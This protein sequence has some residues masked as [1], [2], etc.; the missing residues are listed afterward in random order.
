M[1]VPRTARQHAFVQLANDLAGPI[2][3]RAEQ[4]DRASQF[5]YESFREL[6]DAGYL[7]LTIPEAFGGRGADPLEFGL[8]QERIAHACGSTGLASTMH[9][10]LLGRLGETRLWP[11]DVYGR[12]ARDV[13]ANGALINAANSEPDLGSPS[14]GALP[15]TT[16]VRTPTGW[17]INGRK[18][19]ASLAPALSWVYSLV[20]VQEEG[21]PPRRGNMLIPMSASGVSVIETWDNLGMRGTASHDLLF[22]NV[23]VGLDALLPSEGSSAPGDGQAWWSIPGGAVY[24]G[25]GLAARDAAA[26][27][28]RARIPNGMPGPIAELQMIQH[29]IGEMELLLLQA[30]TLLYQTAEEW[31]ACPEKRAEIAWKLAAAKL[32]VTRHVI[33]VTEIAL[34]VA[35]SAALD[36]G[37]PLQRFFRDA[38]TATG[39]PPMEDVALTLIGKTALGLPTEPPVRQAAT[40]PVRS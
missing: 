4:V 17:R 14:R 36:S 38:R 24:L 19:W 27:Y 29:K 10:S 2:A 3:E 25:I 8:A 7:E 12:V 6:H 9:L 23:E 11:D 1:S 39:H 21:Q 13:I 15:S 40:Q 34:S 33:R 35:G 20:C 5:P 22:E 18:R 30:R 16:A 26:A 28:A 32:T 37:S 31:I